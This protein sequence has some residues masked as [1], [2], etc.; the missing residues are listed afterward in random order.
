MVTIT[1]GH[2]RQYSAGSAA[3]AS[4]R[5]RRSSAGSSRPSTSSKPTRPRKDHHAY[6]N[7][8]MPPAVVAD[9]YTTSHP[10]RPPSSHQQR[11]ATSPSITARSKLH[12]HTADTDEDDIIVTLG[13]QLGEATRRAQSSHGHRPSVSGSKKA[14]EKH[15]ADAI[16]QSFLTVNA[17]THYSVASTL[18]EGTFGQVRRG[19]HKLT[20]LSVAIKILEKDR[21]SDMSD[22]ERVKR[23]IRI[24]ARIQ[25]PNV[26]RLYEVIDSPKHIFLIMEYATGGELFDYIVRH[27]RV[28]ECTACSIFH[29]L[30]NGI[31]QCH[32]SGVIHRDLKPENLLMMKDESVRIVDFGK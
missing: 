10:P 7:T 2:Q 22:I 29:H 23:E 27:Q 26:I 11:P 4:I 6:A 8:F 3:A 25:H 14:S 30:I 31:N 21:I 24:L 19:V 20:G 13:I 12:Q 1:P 32:R 5:Q 28:D 17:L 18:G 16:R 15:R 9:L